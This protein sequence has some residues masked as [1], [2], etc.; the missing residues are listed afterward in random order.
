MAP[1]PV[2]EP[3]REDAGV[4]VRPRRGR[5]SRLAIL[6]LVL[7]LVGAAVLVTSGIRT[8]IHAAS[9]VK[10]ETLDLSTPVVAALHPKLG[11]LKSEVVLPGNIQ[12][13]TDSPIYARAS[14]YLKSWTVDIGA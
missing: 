3:L 10:T 9:E 11:A 4:E 8:R 13:Y 5:G 7:L 2:L 6:G 1:E 12:A 14:G